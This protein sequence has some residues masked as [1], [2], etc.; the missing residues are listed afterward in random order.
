M[1]CDSPSLVFYEWKEIDLNNLIDNNI[2]QKFLNSDKKK[3][4]SLIHMNEF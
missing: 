2:I 3:S 4:N 1:L